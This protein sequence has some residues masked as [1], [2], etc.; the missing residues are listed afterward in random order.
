MR[1]IGW[2]VVNAAIIGLANMTAAWW[3]AESWM[4]AVFVCFCVSLTAIIEL[5]LITDDE[6]RRTAGSAGHPDAPESPYSEE[7]MDVVGFAAI[8][9]GSLI[10]Y[11][12]AA[13][14]AVRYVLP[15]MP[16][17]KSQHLSMLLVFGSLAGV[18]YFLMAW[19]QDKNKRIFHP[20]TGC[21]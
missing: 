19:G 15:A 13:V 16:E 7:Y 12:P 18:F 11:I 5:R 14:L 6:N 10:A 8:G 3:N 1:L 20:P 17:N 4:R 2:A 9:V 21:P